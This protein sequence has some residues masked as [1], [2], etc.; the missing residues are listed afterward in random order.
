[1]RKALLLLTSGGLLLAAAA[2]A[3][4][5]S[6]DPREVAKAARQNPAVIAE[7][8]GAETGRRASYVDAVGRRV[9]AQTG[10]AGSGLHFVTLN[11]AVQNAFSVPGGYIYLTRQLMGLMDDESELAFVLGHE[12]GHIAANHAE[13]RREVQQRNAQY[14]MLGQLLG[15][16]IGGGFGNMIAQDAAVSGTLRTLSFDRSQ[17]YQADQLGIRY[18]TRAGYDPLG[19]ADMLAALTRASALEARVQGNHNRQTPEWAS[20]HPLSQNRLVEARRFAVETGRAGQGARNR[21]AFLSELDGVMVDDDPAQGVIDGRTF[22]HPDLRLQFTVPTGFLMQNST[23]KVEVSGSA[24]QAEFSSERFDGNVATYIGRVV[25]DLTS[26]EGGVRLGPIQRTTVNGIAAAFALGRA[27]TSEGT[28]DIGVFVFP[29][30][31][32]HAYHFTTITRAGQGFGPFVSMLG[33]LRRLSAQEAAA[34]RPRVIEVVTVGR[35]DTVASL[36]ERMAYRDY[37]VERFLSLNGLS[38]GQPLPPGRK[39]KLVVFGTRRRA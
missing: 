34:I 6:L 28:M 9:A 18:I 2:D 30:D 27:A 1:M 35:G 5:V 22:T 12:A 29:F 7:F 11:A 31:A 20:T 23:D 19:G 13:A 21:D 16:L 3:Q 17:E 15:S 32:T 36:A 10:L 26:G 39:V 38:A 4:R 24:G 8:G 37:R 25:A 14:G 33:S